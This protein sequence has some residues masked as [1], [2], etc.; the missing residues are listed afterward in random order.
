MCVGTQG[1]LLIEGNGVESRLSKI[2]GKT[3]RIQSYARGVKLEE[4]GS[5]MRKRRRGISE[6]NCVVVVE[7]K[8]GNSSHIKYDIRV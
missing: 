4:R 8:N 6:Q 2:N 3:Y 7:A 1:G 5:W